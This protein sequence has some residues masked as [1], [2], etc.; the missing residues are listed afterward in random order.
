MYGNTFVIIAYWWEVL[1]FGNTF[2]IIAYWWV[3]LMSG[4]TFVIIAYWC[5]VLMF[6]PTDRIT[7]TSAFITPVVKHWLE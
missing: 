1:M 2:V 3:M 5:E 6:D 7:Y 4:N